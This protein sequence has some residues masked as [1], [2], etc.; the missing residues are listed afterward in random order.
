MACLH[1][2]WEWGPAFPRV[3][4]TPQ[5][6]AQ[7]AVL[8]GRDVASVGAMARGPRRKRCSGR[9]PCDDREICAQRPLAGTRNSRTESNRRSAGGRPNGALPGALAIQRGCRT[10]SHFRA[11][12]NPVHPVNAGRDGGA[13]LTR[14]PRVVSV[15]GCPRTARRSTPA[16]RVRAF[17]ERR[18][19]GHLRRTCDPARF[20]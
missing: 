9:S 18:R 10:G 14:R 11:Q 13:I 1:R 16:L 6:P 19:H 8:A 7:S 2:N 15:R 17:T 4:G 20:E 12:R 5:R 3:S